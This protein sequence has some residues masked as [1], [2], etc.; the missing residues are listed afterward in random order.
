M[1]YLDDKRVLFSLV[2]LARDPQMSLAYLNSQQTEEAD[3]TPMRT[4]FLGYKGQ[5]DSNRTMWT[6]VTKIPIWLPRGADIPGQLAA[7][8][9][10]SSAYLPASRF[11]PNFRGL[12]KWRR[13]PAGE[14]SRRPWRIM[15]MPTP[16][17]PAAE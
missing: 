8:R 12:Q 2:R 5:F 13:T 11:T 6:N 14:P 10:G 16:R 7:A 3:A 15:P 9:T 4:P 17:P 1:R